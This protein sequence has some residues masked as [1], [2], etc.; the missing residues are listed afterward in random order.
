MYIKHMPILKRKTVK[1]PPKWQACK[2]KDNC[3]P[4][5]LTNSNVAVTSW[6]EYISYGE[7]LM[8]SSSSIHNNVYKFNGREFDSSTGYFLYGARYYDPKR[9]IWLSVD[10]LAEITNSPYAYS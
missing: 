5:F 3:A 2:T 9:C 7:M 8:E 6:Y 4:L 1:L 10:P